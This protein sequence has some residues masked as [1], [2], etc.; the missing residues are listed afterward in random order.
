MDFMAGG[1]DD[2]FGFDNFMGGDGDEGGGSGGKSRRK[3]KGG[4]AN[5][6][7]MDAF[8]AEDEVGS[9]T[10]RYYLD[11]ECS[12]T[13]GQQQTKVRITKATTAGQQTSIAK[14]ANAN[15][16]IPEA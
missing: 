8:F 14:T 10:T 9:H 1:A 12:D 13:G 5:E 11:T 15:R 7:G 16:Y 6:E 4:K 3:G 2:A